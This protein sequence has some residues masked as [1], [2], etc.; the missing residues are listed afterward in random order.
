MSDSG[1]DQGVCV[2]KGECF[3]WFAKLLDQVVINGCPLLPGREE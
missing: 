3:L 2:F 1:L